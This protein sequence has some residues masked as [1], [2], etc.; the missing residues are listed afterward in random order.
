MMTPTEVSVAIAPL[1]DRVV[2]L[3]GA[4]R[5]GLQLEDAMHLSDML[6]D[7]VQQILDSCK[8]VATQ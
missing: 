7:A 1:A 5:I 8:Q 4:E 3:A 6:M 2:L